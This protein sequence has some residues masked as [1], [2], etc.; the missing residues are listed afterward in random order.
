ML[1]DHIKQLILKHLGHEPTGGQQSLATQLSEFIAAD[2]SHSAFI[3]RGYAGTGKTTLLSALVKAMDE[4][5]MKYLLLAPTGRAAKVFSSYAGRP[6]YT[7]HRKIYR[8]QST[9][10]GQG[11]FVL[12]KN[13]T[14]HLTILVDEASM[15]GNEASDDSA[16]GSGRLLADMISFI[17]DGYSCKLICMGDRAQLPPVGLPMSPALEFQ[18]LSLLIH[19]WGECELTDVLRQH[20]ESEI[21]LNATRV[22]EQVTH[23]IFTPPALITLGKGDFM[24]ISG[25]EIQE[26]LEKSIDRYGLENVIVLCRSNKR[27]N[28]Y[29]AG[30]RQQ[31][32]FRDEEISTG[33]YLMVVRNNYFWL[34][35][36]PGVDFIANGDILRVTKIHRYTS[37]YDFRFA[38]VTLS[39]TE[40]A[41][42]F[43]AW[44][45]LDSLMSESAGLPPEQN[46]KLYYSV[47]ED[48]PD[49]R[50]K[51]DQYKAAREDPFFNALQVKFS[52]AITCHKAQGGQWKAVFID[53]GY[54]DPSHIRLDF[55]RWFYTAIT[56][57]TDIVFCV[58]YPQ[59][60]QDQKSMR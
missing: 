18:S 4:L 9:R 36:K 56:R 54:M 45:L 31:L 59:Q 7:I 16:F 44:I 15:I 23:E 46:R 8:Q 5:G 28:Q 39:W 2:L 50:N 60:W 40:Y 33:D 43:E 34:K 48:Y 24:F 26:W 29:N 25:L 3:V 35:D 41:V 12:N 13:L 1:R 53:P 30:I 37:R 22:R 55:L 58:N 27:A 42:D 32:L 14:R 38:Y 19:V 51:R 17:K 49:A 11:K 6:A 57:A 20:N 52:Y 21:L 47:L 10:E